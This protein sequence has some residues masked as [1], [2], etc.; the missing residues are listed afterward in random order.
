MIGTDFSPRII[1]FRHRNSQD[2]YRAARPDLAQVTF[3]K[4]ERR[5]SSS[6]GLS[7][8]KT[9]DCSLWSANIRFPPDPAGGAYSALA[10]SLVVFKGPTS[11][12]M[13]KEGERRGEGPV[14]SVK[15]M[16]RNVAAP[17]YDNLGVYRNSFTGD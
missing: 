9:S 17:V 11:K 15:P 10:D 7:R 13:E 2:F 16:A 8:G 6:N 1:I 5:L 3:Q 4:E 12:G 14:K